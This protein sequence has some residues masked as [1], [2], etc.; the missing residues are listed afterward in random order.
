LF[1]QL[2]SQ[3]QLSDSLNA[4]PLC[5]LFSDPIDAKS[6]LVEHYQRVYGFARLGNSQRMILTTG[7]AARLIDQYGGRRPNE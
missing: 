1:S 2:L 4:I 5:P 7:A 3:I 6:E